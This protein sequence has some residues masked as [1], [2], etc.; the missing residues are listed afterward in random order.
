MFDTV[1]RMALLQKQVAY[2]RPGG[3][4]IELLQELQ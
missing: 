4:D 2:Y 1:D 3:P